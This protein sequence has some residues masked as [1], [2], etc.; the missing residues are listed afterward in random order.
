MPFP[1]NGRAAWLKRKR[2]EEREEAEETKRVRAIVFQ[3]AANV[4]MVCRI[5]WAQSMHEEPPRSTG[6]KPSLEHSIACCGSGTTGCHG[7]LQSKRII[8]WHKQPDDRIDIDTRMTH[9]HYPGDVVVD[10]MF[11]ATHDRARA[12][13][14]GEEVAN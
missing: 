2:R 13:L 10:W 6:T 9:M 1:K 3:T 4:C 12:H 8:A 14:R 11:R 5:R 7:L